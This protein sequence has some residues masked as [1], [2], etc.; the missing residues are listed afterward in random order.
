MN[1]VFQVLLVGFVVAVALVSYGIKE[2][3][4]QM[5]ANLDDLQEERDAL[6]G[7]IQTLEAEWAYLN[8][9]ERLEA[10]AERVWG[11]DLPMLQDPTPSQVA[12][13]DSLPW[14]PLSGGE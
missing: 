5:R 7:S 11:A 9:P 6:A 3:V 10:V 8:A 12:T 1:R 14:R 2:E 13:L 4:R